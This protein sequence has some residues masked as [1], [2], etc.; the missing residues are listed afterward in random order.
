MCVECPFCRDIAIKDNI[1]TFVSVFVDTVAVHTAAE[2]S[3]ATR[4]A[5]AAVLEQWQAFELEFEVNPRVVISVAQ[6]LIG[7]DG[8]IKRLK[9]GVGEKSVWL[10]DTAG[11]IFRLHGMCQDGQLQSVGEQ[12]MLLLRNAVEIILEPFELV[13]HHRP[14]NGT[15]YGSLYMQAVVPWACSYRSG[16]GNASNTLTCIV[17]RIGVALTARH[18]A[19]GKSNLFRQQVQENI[20][21][22]Y[23]QLTH[24]PVWGSREEDLVWN[25]LYLTEVVRRP[26]L[27]TKPRL[28]GCFG[29]ATMCSP[30]I[31]SVFALAQRARIR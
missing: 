2:E 22:E 6:L 15:F 13:S 31:P 20:H 1:L 23:L 3:D 30:S 9:R 14:L 18:V 27:V 17:K 24:L 19:S 25:V 21:D 12:V 11:I 26:A 4:D 16:N 10:R 28:S 29:W 8:F 5:R 7:D